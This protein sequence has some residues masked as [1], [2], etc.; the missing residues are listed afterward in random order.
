VGRLASHSQLLK[1]P[2]HRTQLLF[3][4]DFACFSQNKMLLRCQ[5]TGDKSVRNQYQFVHN[6]ASMLCHFF[7]VDV[8]ILIAAKPAKPFGRW[9]SNGR[10]E[11]INVKEEF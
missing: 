11:G 5:L 2:I 9:D 8:G 3:F 4:I 10:F 6:H 1:N 7:F